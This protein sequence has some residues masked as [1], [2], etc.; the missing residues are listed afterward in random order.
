LFVQVAESKL[1]PV[2]VTVPP[3]AAKVGLTEV[4]LGAAMM[5]VKV[6][7]PA[8]L[9]EAPF[10][11]T[12]VE[13]AIGV[14]SA[15]IVVV[16]LVPGEMVPGG[17]AVTPVGKPETV[18][19]TDPLKP[20]LGVTL[21]VSVLLLCRMSVSG[22]GLADSAKDG[23]VTVN[24]LEAPLEGPPEHGMSV[25]A[26]ALSVCCPAGRLLKTAV[27]GLKLGEVNWFVTSVPSRV[28]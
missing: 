22:L 5:T 3:R 14:A 8:M 24:V 18:T 7:V 1:V 20:P 11:V 12:V 23:P 28:T 2:T 16:P 4:M 13:P 26:L 21:M 9:P 19:A 10:K 17:E 25:Y 6:P 15:L 27:A